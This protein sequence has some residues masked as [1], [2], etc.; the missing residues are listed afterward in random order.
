[1]WKAIASQLQ[2]RNSKQVRERWLNYLRPD[3]KKGDWT[4]EEELM[5]FELQASMGNK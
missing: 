1:M 3:L 2:N 4:E 5:L